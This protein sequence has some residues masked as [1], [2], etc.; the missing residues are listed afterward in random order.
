LKLKTINCIYVGNLVYPYP[1]TMVCPC[2][3]CIL[4][5]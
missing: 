5:L 3:N 4:L 1:L 2:D